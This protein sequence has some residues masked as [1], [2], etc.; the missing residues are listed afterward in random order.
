MSTF[1]DRV[2]LI[3]GAG[4]GIGRQLAI[5]LAAEGAR[6]AALDLQ[7]A[8]LESLA[9]ELIGKP[10][11]TVSADVTDL[12]ATRE[13]VAKLESQL[14]PVDCL[15][16]CAGLGRSTP[17]A[18]FNAEDINLII[19]VNL[20]GIVN[21]IGAVLPGMRERKRGQLVGLSSLASY[22][23]LPTMGAYCASKAG[24]NALFDSLRVE[25][26]P[27]G[28]A[29]TTICPGWIK[30]P[31][32]DPLGLPEVVKMPVEKAGAIIVEAIR[33]QRAFLAFPPKLT[34]RVRLLRY[35]P[36]PIG[37]WLSTREMRRIERVLAKAGK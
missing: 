27:M 21:A 19:R 6:I 29:V 14:G 34:W 10:L 5:L 25:C 23:G 30:T 16:A 2:V 11:A 17:A 33:S 36:R 1:R 22:R 3:T 32:T 13:A 12:A 26:K 18:E 35:L 31:M 20:L 15:I 24:V 8:N 7:Q 4:S 37:D 28:I 9:V